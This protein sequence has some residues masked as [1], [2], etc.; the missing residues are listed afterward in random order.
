MTTQTQ[1]M[2]NWKSLFHLAVTI[3][4][5]SKL[6]HSP[7]EERTNVLSCLADGRGFIWANDF[8]ETKDRQLAGEASAQAKLNLGLLEYSWVI[9]H[10]I[11][12]Q[13]DEI[14]VKPEMV[15]ATTQDGGTSALFCPV[16]II[17]T[18]SFQDAVTSLFKSSSHLIQTVLC[19]YACY[20]CFLSIS[21]FLLPPIQSS[22]PSLSKTF[23]K[24]MHVCCPCQNIMSSFPRHHIATLHTAY[25]EQDVMRALWRA[26]YV[27]I[28]EFSVVLSGESPWCSSLIILF[29]CL[30]LPCWRVNLWLQLHMKSFMKSVVHH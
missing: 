26:H 17:N 16:T 9:F 6:G 18:L 27:S 23:K 30:L 4:R 7:K 2:V 5:Y 12:Y 8:T 20:L 19:P 25:A 28:S 24:K 13:G 22:K 29:V 15:S 14:L 1:F 3:L 10:G 11:F 21:S